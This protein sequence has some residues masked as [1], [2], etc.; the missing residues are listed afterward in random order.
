MISRNFVAE[1]IRNIYISLSY[2]LNSKPY[3]RN[4]IYE[5]YNKL[6][7]IQFKAKSLI[8]KDFPVKG[9]II[10]I[11]PENIKYEKDLIKN[12]WRLLFKFINPLFNFRKTE[13]IQI[14]DGAWDLRENLDLFENHI[15]FRSY[16]KH[17]IDNFDWKNT[18]YYKRD[19]KRYY[20]GELRR[21]YKT[22]EELNLKYKFHDRLYEKIKQEGFKTQ[23]EIIESEGNFI[24]YGHGRIMR[25]PD[26]DI[27]VGIGRYGEIIFFDGR[28]R[29]NV[30][31]LLK[32]TKIPV[33]VLVIH[34]KFFL[35]LKNN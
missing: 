12:N 22:V 29:L 3:L 9:N 23:L 20:E 24:N 32:L 6:R 33:R 14:I 17:F 1:I 8:Y 13:K 15:K 16:Y 5:I 19:T 31:K 26:D 10:Y 2:K 27:T 28:H 34:K 25:M 30:A 7:L 21:K 4:L 35:N 11:K 18:P